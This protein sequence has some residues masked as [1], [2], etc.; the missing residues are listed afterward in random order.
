MKQNEFVPVRTVGLVRHPFQ[1]LYHSILTCSWW[2]YFG[3]FGLIFVFANTVFACLYLLEPGSIANATPGS[4]RDAF[5]FSVQTLATIGYGAM[6]PATLFGHV[7]VT[8]E[9]LTGML[10][11]AIVTGITFAKFSRPTARV[12]FSKRVVVSRRNGVPHLMFRM[13]NARRNMILEAQL[14]VIVLV[15]DISTEGAVM[16][17]PIELPLVRDRTAMF[18]MTWTAMH[19]IDEKSLFFGP[20]AMTRL[21][22]KRAE[23]FL[24]LNGMDETFAQPVHARCRYA[25]DDIA[26]DARFKDVLRILEDG[27]REIDY[28]NFHDVVPLDESP[29]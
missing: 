23:I 18:V 10:G 26:Q 24:S 16:R 9:A 22:K 19:A 7:V 11:I 6:A 28:R 5:F 8:L 27:T 13:G 21:R 20:D 29:H 15:E 3:G 14:R 2:Q 4:F 17:A 12:V 1:D 25:L